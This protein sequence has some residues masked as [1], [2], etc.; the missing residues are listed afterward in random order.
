MYTILDKINAILARIRLSDY[1]KYYG[2]AHKKRGE[3]TIVI[4]YLD[5][6]FGGPANRKGRDR[7]YLPYTVTQSEEYV[8]LQ[9]KIESFISKKG[10]TITDFAEGM[11]KKVANNNPYRIGKILNSMKKEYPEE[12]AELLKLY[13]ESKASS[14]SKYL[15]VISRHPYDIAGA[16]TGRSWARQ[17]CMSLEYGK[18]NPSA[19]QWK[20]VP[21]AIELGAMV[22]FL[23]YE[24]DKNINE[25]LARIFIKPYYNESKSEILYKADQTIY[26]KYDKLFLAIVN[27][28]VEQKNEEAARAF[29]HAMINVYTL[30]KGIYNQEGKSSILKINNLKGEVPDEDLLE[31]V[32]AMAKMEREEL[33]EA[34]NHIKKVR[35]DLEDRLYNAIVKF[36]TESGV[37]A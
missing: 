20:T 18:S 32:K 37:K 36:L 31:M 22:A 17:S 10:Y 14:K 34:V 33:F 12:A 29:N 24:H 3:N 16:S 2:E 4:K 7:I 25:P 8:D 6:F 1:K 28:W 19:K 5:F 23:I 27:E 26:G 30:G 21:H 9:N 35:P 11:A 13:N 15:I